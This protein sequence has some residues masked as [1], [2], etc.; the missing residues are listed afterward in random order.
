[1]LYVGENKIIDVRLGSNRIDKIYKSSDDGTSSLRYW[2]QGLAKPYLDFEFYDGTTFDPNNITWLGTGSGRDFWTYI[3]PGTK[4]DIWR[5][6]RLPYSTTSVGDH[7]LGWPRLFCYYSGSF[8]NDLTQTNLGCSCDIIAC[9]NFNIN[10]MRNFDSA[11]SY[12][13]AIKNICQLPFVNATNVN[14]M[15]NYCINI[16][17]GQLAEYTYLS[18][19]PDVPV[20]SSTFAYCGSHSSSGRAE[21]DQI[22]VSWGGNLAPVS[23]K[24]DMRRET[25]ATSWILE[26]FTPNPN[27]F[28]TSGF[29]IDIYTTSS[30]SRFT[31]VNM[32][33]TNVRWNTDNGSSPATNT[34]WYYYPCFF[35]GSLRSSPSGAPDIDWFALSEQPNGSLSGSS[36]DMAGTLDYNLFGHIS[37]ITWSSYSSA[38]PDDFHDIYFGFF[39]TDLS[40]TE[41]WTNHA[42]PLDRA[43]GLLYNN[44]FN[45]LVT[46][47]YIAN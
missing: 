18:S 31:G 19:L 16:E 25:T 35:Q 27:P 8:R 2:R 42:D 34:T 5:F 21:L 29:S 3:G 6:T 11:F 41:I 22:P 32:R 37:A 39:V 38:I 26:S 43:Y 7:D 46:L 17:S 45:A 10:E 15:F 20:H 47:N 1:M 30:V 14:G 24:V 33:K 4:G 36:G 23:K 9:G 40:P 12:A 13:D 44:N 28:L